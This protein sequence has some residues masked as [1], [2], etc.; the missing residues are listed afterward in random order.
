MNF[1]NHLARSAGEVA[2]RSDA[3]EG[4]ATHT[5]PSPGPLRAPTSRKAG[6]MYTHYPS[7]FPPPLL[8]TPDL[9]P[10]LRPARHLLLDRPLEL[11]GLAHEL[12]RRLARA[13]AIPQPK[14]VILAG[15]NGPYSHRC[16]LIEAM[17]DLPCVN[18]G[19]AVGIGLDYL[20]A[21]WRNELHPGETVYLPM[22]Q[23][24]YVR[25]RLDTSLGP[26]AAIMARHDWTT[27]AALPPDRWIA[28]LFAFDLR[29]ALMS[30]IE[31]TLVAGGFHDPRATAS[32]MTNAWGDHIGHTVALGAAHQAAI[33]AM[34]APPVPAV[35]IQGGY[36]A[37]LIADFITWA[38]LHGIRV[39]GGL[40]TEPD[41]RPLP[42]A[43]L[44]AIAAVYRANGADFVILSNHS[45]YPRRRVLRYAI[46]SE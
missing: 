24:Q 42:D 34:E 32:G 21:R 18:G 46:A 40:P 6:E 16:E 45:R 20:F 11:G 33:A 13:A 25:S 31:M 44:A 30:L 10:P 1:L 14:L 37:R 26:D 35:A 27:L 28:A 22:E 39:I 12:N 4:G 17:L 41:A 29:G 36:G 9:I 5:K 15:S 3:G 8:H 43:T 2:E 23:A 7:S 19:V 38:H